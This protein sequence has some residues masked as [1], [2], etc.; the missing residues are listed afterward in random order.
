MYAYIHIDWLS[1]SSHISIQIEIQFVTQ[2]IATYD[3]FLK[4][5]GSFHEFH[6]SVAIH[7][8]F[9]LNIF[10]KMFS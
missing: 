4:R 10:L 7:D 9:I 5:G 6:D 3:G 2:L 1:K 8:N